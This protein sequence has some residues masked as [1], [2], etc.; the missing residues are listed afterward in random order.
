MQQHL[1][2]LFWFIFV[3][4]VASRD[5]QEENFEFLANKSLRET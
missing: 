5:V 3:A 4:F 1:R 2:I